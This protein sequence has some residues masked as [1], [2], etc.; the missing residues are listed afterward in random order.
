MLVKFNIR[1]GNRSNQS[2]IMNT[3]EYID[4]LKKRLR[5]V[6]MKNKILARALAASKKEI[7]ELKKSN[8]RQQKVFN[9]GLP[10]VKTWLKMARQ[11]S[12][13]MYQYQSRALTL[14]DEIMNPGVDF[15]LARVSDAD[16]DA[17]IQDRRPSLHPP[18]KM[19]K[20][21]RGELSVIPEEDEDVNASRRMLLGTFTLDSETR[22][23]A[24]ETIERK[25]RGSM[26]S[27][28][29]PSGSS[30]KPRAPTP[31]GSV[32]SLGCKVR[33][34]WWTDGG[35]GDLDYAFL[36]SPNPTAPLR[37]G[38]EPGEKMVTV[39]AQSRIPEVADPQHQ[40]TASEKPSSST[41]T[42]DLEN[43]PRESF[44][45]NKRK[46]EADGQE[47]VGL[48]PADTLVANG[49]EAYGVD[50]RSPRQINRHPPRALCRMSSPSPGESE[51]T[52]AFDFL[53]LIGRNITCRRRTGITSCDLDL[54]SLESPSPAAAVPEISD[55]ASAQMVTRATGQEKSSHE[56]GTASQKAPDEPPTLASRT[57]SEKGS[58]A[59]F[60]RS[61]ENEPAAVTGLGGMGPSTHPAATIEPVPGV[62]QGNSRPTKR[63]GAKTSR[64]RGARRET[65]EDGT[66]S[67]VA[68][69]TVDGESVARSTSGRPLRSAAIGKN[70]RESDI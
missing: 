54:S 55:L 2:S 24:A 34:P 5:A 63:Q 4:T 31:K 23:R 18:G 10:Q 52:T 41:S 7:S 26:S 40:E 27:S 13:T 62:D 37:Q 22:L 58:H 15:T 42:A 35:A 20:A 51:D 60:A 47:F 29:R 14:L 3:S 65:S 1:W 45:P 56:V 8:G 39:Y 50:Q 49:A 6:I 57:D 64:R 36:E 67:S 32:Q 70:Y 43:A 48:K 66:T 12:H 28:E 38:N 11:H 17:D 25:S 68:S 33:G 59:S 46:E 30:G 44:L 61:K 69:S 16:D 53:R 9:L 19:S 21:Q